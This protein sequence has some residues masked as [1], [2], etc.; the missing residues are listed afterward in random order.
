[1]KQKDWIVVIIVVIITGAVSLIISSS[2]FSA[3]TSIQKVEVVQKVSSE[4]HTP[5]SDDKY[6][7]DKS[8]NP[9]QLIRIGK[10]DAL[11]SET[12]KK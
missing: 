7:N 9:T 3:K 8:I 4:F 1:M 10:V 6:F 11:T 5:A 2:L 12:D